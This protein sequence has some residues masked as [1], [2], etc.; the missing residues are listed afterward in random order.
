MANLWK[1]INRRAS[2]EVTRGLLANRYYNWYVFS[3][4]LS[5]DL[6]G[7]IQPHYVQGNEKREK[8]DEVVVVHNGW[9]ESGGLAD[10]LRGIV[11]T[12]LLCKEMGREFRIL[13]THPFPLEMFLVPNTYDWRIKEKDVIFDWQQATPLCLEIGSESRWQTK[14]QKAFLRKG[15]EAAEGKQVH[16]Y[17]NALFAY[18]EGFGQAFQ[19]LFRPSERLQAAIDRELQTLGKGYVSVSARFMGVF[20]DFKDTM[21]GGLLPGDKQELLLS[22]CIKKLEQ[23]HAK[24]PEVKMLV[25]SDSTTFLNRAR[26][27]PYVYTIPGHILHLDVTEGTK[28]DEQLYQT[29]E[30][31][32]LDFFMIAH[33][34]EVYRLQGKWMRSATGFPFAASLLYG[35]PF[36][37]AKFSL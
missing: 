5:D 7:K 3:R 11:S 14:R 17:T 31:T 15:I 33:A 20:G 24:H 30:K 13:F 35:K 37:K 29:Y 21:E 23:I 1:R 9:T 19:E 2:L 8:T 4:Q 16:I 28:N 32:F 26:Q 34:A 36:H 25:N 27:F 12:Y 10:R 22:S 18:F 6:T